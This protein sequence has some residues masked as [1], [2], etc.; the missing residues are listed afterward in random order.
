MV[1]PSVTQEGHSRAEHLRKSQADEMILKILA[2]LKDSAGTQCDCSAMFT[3]SY[4]SWLVEHDHE[5]KYDTDV[6]DPYYK[7]V[8]KVQIISRLY[9]TPAQV[10]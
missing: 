5:D 1:V 6:L 7:E 9:E 3:S 10:M 8:L 2:A 4:V